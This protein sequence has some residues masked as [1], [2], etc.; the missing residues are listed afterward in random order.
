M[1]N[2]FRN[3]S[4]PSHNPSC[5]EPDDNSSSG[6]P[7]N[8]RLS[9]FF[10]RGTTPPAPT[11]E[12]P[13]LSLFGR[14]SSFLSQTTTTTTPAAAA[15][16]TDEDVVARTR[17][18]FNP[19]SA[20]TPDFTSTIMTV[21]DHEPTSPSTAR[22][23]SRSAT[24]SPATVSAQSTPAR[25]AP[26]PG[27]TSTSM[28][29]DSVK[30]S[31]RG[32]AGEA[33]AESPC[34]PRMEG[35]SLDFREYTAQRKGMYS[36]TSMGADYSNLRAITTSPSSFLR[37]GTRFQGT[38]KSDRQVYHVSVEIKHV[39][40]RESF[41][42]GY[43]RIQDLTE[44]HPTL[45]TYFEGEILGAKH[46][47]ITP[48]ESWGAKPADDISHWSK[49]AAFRPYH[50]A[51]ARRNASSPVFIPE[52]AQQEHIFMRWKEQF[53]V[54]DHRVT[55]IRG[56]SFEGFYY[57]CFN[58]I[59]GEVSGIYFHK[60]SERFQQLELKHVEDRGCFAAVEFR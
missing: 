43:L 53:L 60:K 24:L 28:D 45:T 6:R 3:T 22:S 46:H 54:P 12:D 10:D 1:P 35:K 27:G 42:C 59:K 29:T 30:G 36:A 58:Q 49:F 4:S 48:H 5:P 13:H 41:L 39:D 11:G 15:A 18:A 37:A 7:P 55:T 50:R 44:D 56:A 17:S 31:D 20:T 26:P 8:R 33:E 14:S 47:F 21:V 9:S 40:L 51:A 2:T 38:Q 25:D 52:H 34:G 32:D 23:R 57:I 16:P 19:A